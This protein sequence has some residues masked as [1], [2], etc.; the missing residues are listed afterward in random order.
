MYELSPD[1]QRIDD[2][3][4]QLGLKWGYFTSA[5][6]NK[7]GYQVVLS[8]IGRLR[9]E[10][11]KIRSSSHFEELWYKNAIQQLDVMEVLAHQYHG[12][13]KMPVTALID[14]ACGPGT[15]KLIEESFINYDHEEE[16]NVSTAETENQRNLLPSNTRKAQVKIEEVA[17]NVTNDVLQLGIEEGYLPADFELKFELSLP[18]TY[19]RSYWNPEKKMF[20]LGYDYFKCHDKGDSDN[21]YVNPAAAYA[22][23]FHEILGHASHQSH[24][25]S[26]PRSLRASKNTSRLVPSVVISE[27]LAWNRER[28]VFEWLRN[29]HEHLGLELEDIDLEERDFERKYHHINQ[30]I[31]LGILKEREYFEGLDIRNYI[32]KLEDNERTV[33]RFSDPTGSGFRAEACSIERAMFEIC[34]AAG[35]RAV[36]RINKDFS[37]EDEKKFR[38]AQSTGHWG[39]QTYP[40]AIEYFLEDKE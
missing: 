38:T 19:G 36:G 25:E 11:G 35:C 20:F 18:G 26:M 39:W 14:F 6:G 10:L 27:G 8:D 29:R 22:V 34:Y 33:F 37:D 28:T 24:S 9:E 30:F 17:P 1:A 23:A 40:D 3:L 7:H 2:S 4:D 16:W 32:R 15:Y 12:K 21:I 13:P 31:I 5:T